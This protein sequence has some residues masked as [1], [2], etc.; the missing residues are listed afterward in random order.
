M[1]V[2]KY[3]W[4]LALLTVGCLQADTVASIHFVEAAQRGSFNS[5]DRAQATVESVFNDDLQ[6]EVLKVGYTIAGDAFAGVWSK[7]Y[8]EGLTQDSKDRFNARVD[9]AD[10]EPASV[11]ASFELKGTSGIQLVDAKIG[12]DVA[13]A[14]D[15]ALIGELE[16]VVLLI[17][18]VGESEETAGTLQVDVFFDSLS[19]MEKMMQSRLFQMGTV[20]AASLLALVLA[21]IPSLKLK[22]IARDITMGVATT[23]LV[24]VIFAIYR[25]ACQPMYLALAGA[26]IATLYKLALA[27]KSLTLGEAFRAAAVTGFFAVASTTSQLWVAPASLGGFFVLSKF[28]AAL[29]AAIF[30][31]A[32]IFRMSVYKKHIGWIGSIV[33]ALAPVSFGLLLAVQTADTIWL[34]MIYVLIFAQFV[35]NSANLVARQKFVLDGR[36]HGVLALFSAAVVV[37]PMIADWGSAGMSDAL[38]PVIAV[39]A[40][41]V[42]QAPLWGLVFVLTGMAVDAMRGG[43]PTFGSVWAT[44]KSGAI[45]GAVFSGVLMGLLQ[46]AALVGKTGMV[47]SSISLVVLGLLVFPLAKTIIETFDG[48][49]SFFGRALNSYKDPV[50]Y[51]RGLVVG[52]AFAIGLNMELPTLCTSTRILF[53]AGFGF[54]AFGGVSMVRDILYG[55]KSWRYYLVEGLLGAFIGAGLGFYFDASQMPI[56]AT[57]FQFYTSFGMNLDDVVN[58]C[59]TVTTARPDEF[60][61]I[62]SNWGQVKL[63]SGE[64]IGG[65]RIL[66][67]EAL[68]GVIGWGIAAPLFAINKAFL[69]AILN[70]DAASIKRIF[71]KDGFVEITEGTVHVLRW[72]LWMAPIIFTFLRP[73]AEPTWYNQ[74]GLIRTVF[75]TVHSFGD[76]FGAWSIGVFTMIIGYSWFRI[77]IFL[78]HMLLRVA[79]LVNLSF[80]GMDKL[81]EKCATFVG[82]DATARFIP[83]G[84]KRF[85][86]WAPL[87][88]PF[89]LPTKPAEV[90]EQILADGTAMQANAQTFTIDMLAYAIVFVVATAIFAFFRSRSDR[91]AATAE[92]TFRLANNEYSVELKST[93][94]IN[95]TLTSKGYGLTRPAFE[96]VEPAGRVLYVVDADKKEGWPVLGN[97]P[98]ELFKQSDYSQ[99]G[100][101][102]TAVN[103]QNDVRTTVKVT[104]PNREDAAEIWDVNVED[105]SG[106]NRNLKLVP[107]CEWMIHNAGTDRNH[108][109]YNRLYPEMS[110]HTDLNAIL[111]LHR[112]TKY[113]GILA[114]SVQPEGMLSGRVDFIG[115]AGSIWKPRVF[116]TLGF[117]EALNMEAYPSFDPI[118]ALLIDA[119]KPVKLLIGCSKTKKTAAEWINKHIQPEIDKSISS[120]QQPLRHPLIGHGE[121]LP[122]TPE[123]YTEYEDDGNTLRVLTP[124]TPRPFDHEMSNSLGHV[125]AVTNR[126][127]H[128]TT[129]GN[130]QQN[131]LTTDW[132]DV[133]GSQMPAE[134]FYIFDEGNNEWYAP[135]Y[136]PL[137]DNDAKQDVRFGLDGTAVFNMQKGDI[138]TELSVHVPL[139]EPTGVYVLKIKN[140]GST[141]KKL[142]VAPY[143]QIALAHSPEM[144]GKLKIDRDAATGAMFFENPRNSFREGSCFVAMSAPVESFTNKRGE[145]FGQGR[146]F[147]H[148]AMVDAGAAQVGTKDDFAVAAMTTSIELAAGEEQTISVV[149]GQGD[150]RKQANEVVAKFRTVEAAE[151]SIA[152]TRE[153]WLALQDTLELETSDEEFD[154]YVKWMKYQALAERIWARKGFYQASGAFGFRDQLQDTVNMIWVDPK[155]ARA[156]LK[157]H[158]SQQFPEGDVVHWFFRQQDG[159]SGFLCRSH[160][161]DNLL[162]LGW[163]IAEYTRMTGDKSLLDERVTYLKAETPLQGLPEGKHGMGFYPLRSPKSD[164][165]FEHVL[166]AF[167][168]VFEKRLGPNGLPLIGAG[169]WNDG[170]DEIGSEGRG[171]SVWLAFFLTYILKNFLHII[172]ERSGK[173]RREK[174]ENRMKALE[175]NVEKVWRNDRYLRAIH[176]DGTEIGL[177]GAG[178]WETDALGAAWAVYADI[179]RDRARTAVDT[180]LKVLERDNVISLGFPPLREDTKPYLGRSSRYPEGVRENGMYSH[181]VQWLTR[182]CRLLSERFAEE[183]N[184]EL[185]KYYRDACARIWYKVSAITHVTKEEIE[186]YGGQPNKQCADYLTKYDQGRM[187]WNGYTGAAAWMLRQACESVLG[188]TLINNEVVMPKDMDAPRDQLTIKSLKRDVSKSPLK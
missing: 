95:S 148:P 71:T 94:E 5:D 80:L 11:R 113:H 110:Y 56:I 27:G 114:S 76:G 119:K 175:A 182:A 140:T 156:Q 120:K 26:A 187:I 35:T 16:E 101:V 100:D 88:I 47:G 147:A 31:V 75:A 2:L 62:I 125:L 103:E 154:A 164:N 20:L 55:F 158:A 6:R 136:D 131:R 112:Y 171:E 142:R 43:A 65:S 177:E 162:W 45:K 143:F 172:E 73:M 152:A 68:M 96:N 97:F 146:S 106:Q 89:Y 169:D 22:G 184:E 130:A 134:A 116:E 181:G 59:N 117:R 173:E 144:A 123:N 40:T 51:V 92:K 153:W 165:I 166:K 90:W 18:R 69:A 157:L 87:L 151:K 30:H 178:Y 133:T 122:G 42:S 46:I 52:L 77:I 180:A 132:A 32:G 139:D 66:F 179:N 61:A 3:V 170:L 7:D 15:W 39:V 176:D 121:V 168:C 38:N 41:M 115:R 29:F 82:K 50:L 78:D 33:C 99:D 14:I 83:E 9:S 64:T 108:S 145:F 86:T 129:N 13:A 128:S 58:A 109:Q 19:P 188:A 54:A 150:D 104:L 70:K 137:K 24:A 25:E 167:D 118:G 135:T 79:T 21:F 37:A 93:G 48:S 160:A 4:M 159:R 186:L 127:L 91:N 138:E 23:L 161:Y 10:T 63:F 17:H 111:A 53:G 107:Y 60:N 49:Q 8:P 74:D 174:Y 149:L 126:G 98:E 102:I 84:V 57:K 185:A 141:A 1:K 67:N 72:G 124:F 44:A 81:D 163:G 183:G 155:L 85:T 28:G 105:L 36:I 34:Q 12:E